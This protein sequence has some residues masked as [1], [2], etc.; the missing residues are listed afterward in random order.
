MLA[1]KLSIS[2]PPDAVAF[3]ETYRAEHAIRSRSQVVEFALRMLREQSLEAAYREANSEAD[4]AWNVVNSE[5]L[6]DETW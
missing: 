6:A 2:L 4:S 1:E 5:G 3:I